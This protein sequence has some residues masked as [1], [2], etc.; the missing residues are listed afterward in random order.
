MSKRR[1]R[2]I[3]APLTL[4]VL[5]CAASLASAS[6]HYIDSFDTGAVAYTRLIGAGALTSVQTGLDP[7]QVLGGIRRMTMTGGPGLGTL[8]YEVQPST[9]GALLSTFSLN[10]SGYTGLWSFQYGYAAD[11]SFLDLNTDLSNGGQNTAFLVGMNGAEHPYEVEIFVR[12]SSGE[13]ATA[14]TGLLPAIT[15]PGDVFVPFS[16][17]AFGSW[18]DVDQIVLTLRGVENGDYQINFESWG[19]LPNVP[20]PL[21]MLTVMLAVGGSAAYARR[22]LAGD[23]AS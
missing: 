1:S 5:F 18:D 2:L 7:T 11:G 9:G 19:P 22:R 3:V 6:T 14:S 17:F 20:E 16:Q 23:T 21:T 10:G 4:A 15:S 13:T 12:S 8:S